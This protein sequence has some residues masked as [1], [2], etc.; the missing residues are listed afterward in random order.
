M[1]SLV[2]TSPGTRGGQRVQLDDA[3]TSAPDYRHRVKNAQQ[4]ERPVPVQPRPRL[5]SSVLV[6][7]VL[8]WHLRVGVDPVAVGDGERVPF[9]LLI[10]AVMLPPPFFMSRMTRK[11]TL[12]AALL[13]GEVA[14]AL[15]WPAGSW[16]SGSRSCWSSSPDQQRRTSAPGATDLASA[17]SA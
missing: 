15:R 13:A 14:A 11:R 5:G 9:Q 17:G 6:C 4:L 2:M 7:D 1:C 3:W 16:R 10:R 8:A 12:S